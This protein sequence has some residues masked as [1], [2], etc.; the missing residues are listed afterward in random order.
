MV[1][2][3]GGR[4][5]KSFGG[6]GGGGAGA[7][8]A[9]GGEGEVCVVVCG[10]RGDSVYFGPGSAGPSHTFT[11]GLGRGGRGVP[12]QKHRRQLSRCAPPACFPPRQ[13][14]SLPPPAPPPRPGSQCH[15]ATPEGR[16]RHCAWLH[17]APAAPRGEQ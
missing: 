1:R 11:R 12:R 9:G 6:G 4:R 13:P 15:T 16:P 5:P 17:T 10:K 8:G 2:G 14:P 7:G 3:L